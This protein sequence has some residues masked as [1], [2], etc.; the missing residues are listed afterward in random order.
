LE[1]PQLFGQSAYTWLL[2][3]IGVALSGIAAFVSTKFLTKYFESG[4]LT[5]FALYC[6]IFGLISLVVL[7]FL[8]AS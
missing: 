8:H 5:P 7:F 1:I 6:L 2:I 3:I 4:R